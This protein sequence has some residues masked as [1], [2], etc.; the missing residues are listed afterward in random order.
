VGIGE[1]ARL[2]SCARCRVQVRICR[3]CDRGN[4]YCGNGCARAQ[5]REGVRRA[6][7]RYQRTPRGARRHAA[8]Q[9]AWRERR[10]ATSSGREDWRRALSQLGADA[11]GTRVNLMP[12]ILRCVEA[13]A[14]VGEIC[15]TLEGVFGVYRA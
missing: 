6:G 13:G 11:S 3:R 7:S 10:E 14:T 2:Y 1:S 8:R 15:T 12:A 9:R 4:V 5:R